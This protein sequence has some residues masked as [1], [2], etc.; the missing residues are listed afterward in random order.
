VS[1]PAFRFDVAAEPEHLA[2][3]PAARPSA[4]QLEAVRRAETDARRLLGRFEYRLRWVKPTTPVARQIALT[5][6]PAD[7]PPLVYLRVDQPPAEIY[8]D[9][10][11]EFRHVTDES[12][13]TQRRIS[14]DEAE[15]RAETFRA[16]AMRR[17]ATAMKTRTNGHDAARPSRPRAWRRGFTAAERRRANEI[18]RELDSLGGGF[19]WDD[20]DSLEAKDVVRQARCLVDGGV[21]L[22]LPGGI[23]RRCAS[24]HMTY[25][26]GV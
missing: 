5:R 4:E 22:M 8:A 11:H 17:G 13:I 26:G 25:F 9:A 2:D 6:Y 18:L 20:G 7:G 16:L 21:L 12:L 14:V 3:S 24:C 19:G 1:M 15:R 10:L 23:L